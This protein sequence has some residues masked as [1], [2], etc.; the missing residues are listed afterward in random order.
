MKIAIAKGISITLIMVFIHLILPLVIFRNL[1]NL[2]PGEINTII[3]TMLNFDM[4]LVNG[5]IITLVF[6]FWGFLKTG[7][8]E[9]AIMQTATLVVVIIYLFVGNSIYTLYLST[10]D[11]ATIGFT[12]D[13][14]E[15]GGINLAFGFST[16]A[17]LIIIIAAIFAAIA[18]LDYVIDQMDF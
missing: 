4:L 18:W 5:I 8:L 14:A 16:L 10:I 1:M 2:L 15:L 7:T 12:L 6:G 13:I 3:S 17:I 9:K 11:F